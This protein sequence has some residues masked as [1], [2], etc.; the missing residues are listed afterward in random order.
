M[1]GL[2]V[3]GVVHVQLAAQ[4]THDD[5]ARVQSDAYEQRDSSG[6]AHLLRVLPDQLLH[7]ERGKTG[8]DGVVLISD[9]GP[10]KR[11]DSVAHHLVDRALVASDS[12]HHPFENGVKQRAG[13][14]GIKLGDILGR[15]LHVRAQHGH[16]LPL[17]L[18]RRF[19]SE[20]ALGQV[21]GRVKEWRCRKEGGCMS[22]RDNRNGRAAIIAKL[23]FGAQMAAASRAGDAERHAAF[24]AELC[25]V[26]IL[27]L[28]SWTLHA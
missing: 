8:P 10:E 21:T 16:L 13:I 2:A 17:A 15:S 9:R 24:P 28:A 18:L 23:A 22:R 4:R 12:F 11:L 26:A 20:D 7:F 1:Y 14:L 27:L 3:S 25:L 5:F 19:G 6:P